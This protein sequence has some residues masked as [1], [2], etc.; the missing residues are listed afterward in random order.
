[1]LLLTLA[2]PYV[3]PWFGVWFVPYLGLMRDR[4]VAW[5]GIAAT[6]L[7]ALTLIPADP[8]SGLSTWGVMDGVHYV[9]APLML[10][11]FG[12]AAAR[13]LGWRR[14]APDG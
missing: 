12:T 7:L 3:L 13:V 4:L 6:T 9:V 2:W 8:F 11:L 14:R 1:M 5:V 10:V